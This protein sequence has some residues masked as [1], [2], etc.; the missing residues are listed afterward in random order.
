MSNHIFKPGDR[1]RSLRSGRIWVV[2]DPKTAP[3]FDTWF[4][5]VA[6]RDPNWSEKTYV[7]MRADVFEKAYDL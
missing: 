4:D 3:P 6:V 2:C 1:L 5:R 7:W